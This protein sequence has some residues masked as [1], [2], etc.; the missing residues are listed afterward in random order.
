MSFVAFVE[1]NWMLFATLVASGGMLT[2]PLLSGRLTGGRA[3]GTLGLSA[4]HEHPESAAAGPAARL[5]RVSAG[6]LPNADACAAGVSS[7]AAA[8]KLAKYAVAAGGRLTATVA[9]AAIPPRARLAKLGFGH[10]YHL[11]GGFA[12]WKDAG[13]PVSSAATAPVMM[14]STCGLPLLRPGG[15]FPRA[16]GVTDIDKVRVDLDPSRRR[17]DDAE[18]RPPHRAA[19]IYRRRA[20]CRRILRIWRRWTAPGTSRRSR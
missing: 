5:Q 11:Q 7:R 15:E 8:P 4:A 16:K 3:I 12:A 10:I 13:L 17:G 20:S 19:E 6:K 18:D 14:Y 1:K 2:R 9:S